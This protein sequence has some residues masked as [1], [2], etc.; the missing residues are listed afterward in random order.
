MAQ[1]DLELPPE[2]FAETRRY[3]ELDRLQQYYDGTQYKGRPSFWDGKDANG[4]VVPLRD[5]RPCIVASLPRTV[6]RHVARFALGQ[7]RFP[8]LKVEPLEPDQ[9]PYPGAAVS[10]DDAAALT[11]LIGEL[12]KEAKLPSVWRSLMRT[13]L[14][15]RTAVAALLLRDGRFSFDLPRPQ[16][17]WPTFEGGP[18]TPIKKLVWSYRFDKLVVNDQGQVE[19]QPHYFRRDITDQ[20][21]VVYRDAPIRHGEK[22]VWIVDDAATVTHGLGF[23]PVV[24]ARNT[25]DDAGADL[26]GACLYDDQL[27]E[28]DALNFALSQR[29]RGINYWGT[30]QP[31]ESG[32]E[33]DSVAADFGMKGGGPGPIGYS[34]E[35]GTI[36]LGPQEVDPFAVSG[37]SDAAR[38]AAPDQIWS[39]RGENAKAGL[40]E[41]TG[42]SFEAA[43]NH[44]EDVKARFL[45]ATSVIL[46]DAEKVA[47]KGDLSAKFLALAY[48]PML[49]LVDELREAWWHE[50]YAP[51]CM[52]AL[53]IIATVDDTIY[54]PGAKA[55]RPLL[56]RF[57]VDGAWR[58]PTITPTWGHYFA[59]SNAEIKEGV[60]VAKD[61]KDAGL[62]SRE[63]AARYVANDLGVDDVEAELD[64]IDDEKAEAAAELAEVQK[65]TSDDTAPK[66]ASGDTSQPPEPGAQPDGPA[67]PA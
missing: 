35:G 55:A 64:A 13:G 66:S 32:V 16:D 56:K 46:I 44:V 7:G 47:A 33:D 2:L 67:P 58:G 5:R 19:Y 17:C 22:P 61:A 37:P 15:R 14:A 28:L 57:A 1:D 9:A 27:D 63:T 59:P 21:Y 50:C 41:T 51:I 30:P 36:G 65:S 3:K 52:M 48:A 11:A 8:A 45:E 29:H 42:K 34:S 10:D 26:D 31:W 43:T 24:W 4:N 53:R 39:Y 6:V 18:G 54:L 62:V 49:A 40:L 12:V 60:A 23:C 25:L 38:K 20:H